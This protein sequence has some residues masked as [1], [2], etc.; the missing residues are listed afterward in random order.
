MSAVADT[1]N[2][3]ALRGNWGS[4]RPLDA[5]HDSEP[6]FELTHGAERDQI[7][8]EMKVGPFASAQAFAD[9]ARELSEDRRRAFFT[10]LDPGERPLGWLCLME[11]SIAHRSVELGYVLYS[12]PLQRTTLATEAYYLV[13]AHVFETLGFE[14]L[15]WTCTASNVKSLRAAERLGFEF[16]GVMRRKLVLK[17]RPTDIAMCSLLSDEWP[18]R[19][20]AMQDWLAPSNFVNGAQ[21][22]PLAQKPEAG[23]PG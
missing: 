12:P 18:G 8:R 11:A 15:E 13:M 9:H 5:A 1:L 16:E 23:A 19:R 4:L 21:V 22:R 14:R 6:L 17:D 20:K 10:V 7:W 3:S 2:A